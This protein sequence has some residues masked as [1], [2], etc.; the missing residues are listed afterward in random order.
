MKNLKN[1]LIYF[2]RYWFWQ[3]SRL[4]VLLYIRPKFNFKLIKGSDKIPKPPFIMVSNHGTFFDPWIF[5][6]IRFLRNCSSWNS[7]GIFRSI[8]VFR[9]HSFRKYKWFSV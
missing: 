1:K 3:L 5:S 4:F 6:G 8:S 2:W 7:P 9:N